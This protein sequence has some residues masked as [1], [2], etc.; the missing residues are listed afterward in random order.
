VAALTGVGSARPTTSICSGSAKG[1]AVERPKME[2]TTRGTES[3]M[4]GEG[5]RLG[6][7]DAKLASWHYSYLTFIPASLSGT[8][9]ISGSTA[10]KEGFAG[11]ISG[12]RRMVAMSFYQ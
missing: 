10:A 7:R 11:S 9:P 2:R 3:F 8:R 5:Q 4:A 1:A 6:W 12:K